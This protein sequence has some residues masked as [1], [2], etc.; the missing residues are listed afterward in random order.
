M[1]RAVFEAA[2]ER[3][4][5]ESAEGW[6][7]CVPVAPF[8]RAGITGV[9]GLIAAAAARHPGLTIGHTVNLLPSGWADVVVSIRFRR[10]GAEAAHRLLRELHEEFAAAGYPP[11]RLD[12]DHQPRA[13]ALRA[14]PGQEALLRRLKAALDPQDV[15]AR[16]RYA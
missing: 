1:V 13:A 5:T 9:T 12:V 6:L 11:Y 4:E 3:V 16:G 14:D 2:P 15:I 7:F 8:T 10:A